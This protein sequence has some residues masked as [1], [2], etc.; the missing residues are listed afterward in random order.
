[1]GAALAAPLA[2]VGGGHFDAINEALSVGPELVA[3]PLWPLLDLDLHGLCEAYR[4]LMELGGSNVAAADLEEVLGL[5]PLACKV[6]LARRSSL[7]TFELLA[8]LGVLSHTHAAAKARFLHSLVD[9]SG[10]GR[11]NFQ[12]FRSVATALL[13][14]AC[15]LAQLPRGRWPKVAAVDVLVTPLFEQ[16]APDISR[17]TFVSMLMNMGSLAGMLRRFARGTVDQ[18][19]ILNLPTAKG[20]PSDAQGHRKPMRS[21]LPKRSPASRPVMVGRAP[22]P[23]DCLYKNPP[24]MLRPVARMSP[25]QQD[26]DGESDMDVRTPS[27]ISPKGRSPPLTPQKPNAGLSSNNSRRRGYFQA[28]P[29]Q[30][31][32]ALLDKL[33]RL[34][35]E[36]AE[37]A[38]TKDEDGTIFRREQ[39]IRDE[40]RV[41]LANEGRRGTYRRYVDDMRNG[42]LSTPPG[43]G[44][45]PR[46]RFW[47][48]SQEHVAC[49]GELP[50]HCIR[51]LTPGDVQQSVHGR[52]AAEN[53]QNSG[54]Q[55][56]ERGSHL[57]EHSSTQ[58]YNTFLS[59]VLDY[60]KPVGHDSDDEH[61]HSTDSDLTESV[62]NHRRLM[63]T[64]AEDVLLAFELYR[65]GYW[66]K[67]HQEKTHRHQRDEDVD[68]ILAE[69]AA[70]KRS[71]PS[72]RKNNPAPILR[73]L[74]CFFQSIWPAITTADFNVFL[75]IIRRS[76]LPEEAP[77]YVHVDSPQ[78]QAETLRE[79]IELFDAIDEQGSAPLPPKGVVP[80]G[81]VEQFLCG[82]LLTAREIELLAT[83]RQQF[84]T[85]FV[86]KPAGCE[87]Y[88]DHINDHGRYR[89]MT[90]FVEDRDDWAVTVPENERRWVGI[91]QRMTMCNAEF[92]TA[93]RTK[94]GALYKI[95]GQRMEKLAHFIQDDGHADKAGM[96]EGTD[97]IMDESGSG[98]HFK[99]PGGDLEVACK[100]G[101]I[102]PHL[103]ES[104]SGASPSR[105]SSA[106]GDG[107]QRRDRL[108]LVRLYWRYLLGSAVQ[109]QL[110]QEGDSEQPSY[111]NLRA[112][113][114]ID[115]VGFICILAHDQ[116]RG[117][118]PKGVAPTADHI[119][120]SAHAK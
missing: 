120:V 89:F 48:A 112:D 27:K 30:H 41:D 53:K 58:I 6:I 24:R 44:I 105:P 45:L 54:P 47:T 82:E 42:V 79:L 77:P 111:L 115:L 99:I 20:K 93:T 21:V 81:A 32:N 98:T 80:L 56:T 61:S 37:V 39:E 87:A 25:N 60:K 11:L 55:T 18:H 14:S 92:P 100:P 52:Q 5:P 28:V 23:P 88:V 97:F 72:S 4:R 106:S 15:F 65:D 33:R 50:Y 1:M 114:H 78:R 86:G 102:P 85:T 10:T 43:V 91:Q 19:F 36:K 9:R 95:I 38:K 57:V 110:R 96:P 67:D 35:D 69:A 40:I 119:R 94:A 109:Q 62:D 103:K 75:K 7:Q 51:P 29:S 117:L 113:G 16:H 83:Q 73:S 12:E 116:L 17:D 13:R 64:K 26:S 68:T 101:L 108:R 46:G 49:G 118:F 3:K 34:Y 70:A 22:L 71:E 66:R 104:N 31:E 63:H 8:L 59:Q 74:H 84:G 2:T 76:K 90:T 107:Q